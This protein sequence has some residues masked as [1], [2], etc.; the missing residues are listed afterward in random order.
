ISTA[1]RRQGTS[2]SQRQALNE[3]K[4]LNNGNSTTEDSP[5]AKKTRTCQKKNPE[6]GGKADKDRTEDRQE[7]VK[8]LLLKGKAPVDP[9]CTAKVGKA[10]VY[11]EGNDVYDVITSILPM[12]PHTM[13]IP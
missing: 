9:E 4:R 3:T 5:L 2:Y 11:C 6:T 12:L 10:H 8:A 1:A 13:T 7:S